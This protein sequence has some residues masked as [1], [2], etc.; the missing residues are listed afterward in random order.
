M[1]TFGGNRNVLY[2][3]CDIGYMSVG[4]AKIHQSK[5]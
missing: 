2:L 5:H 3:D 1:E 4:I